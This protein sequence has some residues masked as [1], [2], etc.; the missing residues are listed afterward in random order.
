[1]SANDHTHDRYDEFKV[2]GKVAESAEWNG[3]G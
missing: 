2:S 3:S 1:M